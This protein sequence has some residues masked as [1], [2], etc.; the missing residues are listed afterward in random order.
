MTMITPSYLG[1]TIEYSSLHACR[2]TLEDPTAS[3]TEA[4][5]LREVLANLKTDLEAHMLKEEWW[6]F[7][8]IKRW[9]AARQS[10][11]FPGVLDGPFDALDLEHRDAHAALERLRK[12]ICGL[13]GLPNA[14]AQLSALA[15]GLDE[16]DVAIH[17]HMFEESGLLFPRACV[18][19]ALL[20]AR[21]ALEQGAE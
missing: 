17:Q 3:H 15:D 13:E 4:G 16:L 5:E 20:R 18:A 9:E 19:A 14:C 2:S 7:P 8:K 6:V 21:R 10:G 12:L 11:L 1:E